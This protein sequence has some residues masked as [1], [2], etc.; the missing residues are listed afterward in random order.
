KPDNILVTA[1]GQ[2]KLGDLG[3]IKELESELNLTCPQQGLG[4]PNF[5]SPEQFTE[6]RAADV[7]CDIYSLGTTL[8]M[9]VTGVLPFEAKTLAATL[10]KTLNNELTPPREIVPTLSEAV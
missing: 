2:A 9:A 7:R 6:A 1:N 3:L 5:M 10:R 8:Y 4:T